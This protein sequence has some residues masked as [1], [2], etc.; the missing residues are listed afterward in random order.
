MPDKLSPREVQ[1]RIC[2]LE[3]TF[4]ELEDAKRR[5]IVEWELEA[6]RTC[7]AL[8]E[9]LRHIIHSSHVFRPDL[10]DGCD[11]ARRLLEDK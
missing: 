9:A 2:N 10:C 4:R 3:A 11:Q 8:E 7:A 5:Q 6:L 1:E